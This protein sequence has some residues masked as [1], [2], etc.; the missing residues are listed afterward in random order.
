MDSLLNQSL[1]DTDYRKQIFRL[2]SKKLQNFDRNTLSK[3]FGSVIRRP[4][5]LGKR[6]YDELLQI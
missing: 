4:Q 5:K 6:A 1:P 3:Y 2:V